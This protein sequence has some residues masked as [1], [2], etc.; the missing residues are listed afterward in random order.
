MWFIFPQ[1]KGLGWSETS[2]FYSIQDIDEARSYLHHPILGS[3]LREISSALLN[4]KSN[5]ATAVMGSPDDLKLKSC[6]TLFSF[7]DTSG[8]S[9]FKQ[10]LHTFYQGEFDQKTLALL[11][12]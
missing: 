5:D 4:L 2:Q 3:R 1:Y 7:V 12:D 9:L 8:E 10:V 6:M 11:N